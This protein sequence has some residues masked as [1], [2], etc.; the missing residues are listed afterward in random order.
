MS[1]EQVRL[2]RKK[3]VGTK[4]ALKALTKGKVEAVFVASDADERVTRD[5]IRECNQRGITV[6]VVDSMI[7]LGKACGIQVGAAACAIVEQ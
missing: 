3:A 7:A 1:I 2:A 5:I 4:Q 6:N